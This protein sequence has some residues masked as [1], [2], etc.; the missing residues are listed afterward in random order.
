MNSL[1]FADLCRNSEG[2]HG[3]HLAQSYLDDRD[4]KSK[5]RPDVTAEMVA[6]PIVSFCPSRLQ[7]W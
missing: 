2:P 7:I 5:V 4:Q 6:P 3:G 1:S